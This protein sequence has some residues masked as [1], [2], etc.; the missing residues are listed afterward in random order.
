MN[1]SAPISSIMST[2]LWTVN[3]KDKVLAVKKIFDEHRIHHIPVVRFKEIVGMISSSDFLHFQKGAMGSRTDEH[4]NEVRIR[5]YFA[6]EIMTS[7]LAKLSSTET[8]AVAIQVFKEN[9]FHAIPIVDDGDLVGILTTHDI[10][11]A[12]ASEIGK[13]ESI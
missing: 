12:L 7:N 3:P 1:L 9:L 13:Q 8:L 5:N 2:K 4:I 11:K 10:I 6:E